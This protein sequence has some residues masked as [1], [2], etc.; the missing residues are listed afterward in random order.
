MFPSAFNHSFSGHTVLGDSYFCQHLQE[1]T[2]NVSNT[3]HYFTP[4]VFCLCY[5][6]ERCCPK[7]IL[8]SVSC[9]FSLAVPKSSLRLHSPAGPLWWVQLRYLFWSVLR[10]KVSGLPA[11]LEV[12]RLFLQRLHSFHSLHSSAF[13]LLYSLY[14]LRLFMWRH[15]DLP[16]LSPAIAHFPSL[17]LSMM[18]F[19]FS[20][21]VRIPVHWSSLHCI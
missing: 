15:L 7:T 10:W 2:D 5:C 12:P 9:L 18:H 4:T 3:L 20:L 8:S 17:P 1:L 21:Q 19:R 13:Y 11:V 6:W 14:S 16:F